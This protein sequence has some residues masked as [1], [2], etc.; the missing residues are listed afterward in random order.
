MKWSSRTIFIKNEVQPPD[1]SLV[2]RKEAPPLTA[3]TDCDQLQNAEQFGMLLFPFSL[4][5]TSSSSNGQGTAL[6]PSNDATV[7]I[8]LP[9]INEAAS[10]RSVA[11]SLLA[12]LLLWSAGIR[13]SRHLNFIAVNH[14]FA[15]LTLIKDVI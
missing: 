1:D 6:Y 2:T 3:S 5:S 9:K 10:V 12:H 8:Y 7:S 14:F 13:I 4:P 11:N 15:L